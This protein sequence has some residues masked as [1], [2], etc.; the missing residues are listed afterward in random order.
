MR[1]NVPK[2]AMPDGNGRIITLTDVFPLDI[3]RRYTSAIKEQ[4]TMINEGDEYASASVDP[5]RH[6]SSR[7]SPSLPI[8]YEAHARTGDQDKTFPGASTY[9]QM[10]AGLGFPP[11]VVNLSQ[12]VQSSHSYGVLP[13]KHGPMDGLAIEGERAIADRLLHS[14]VLPMNNDAARNCGNEPSRKRG[15]GLVHRIDPTP[16]PNSS[17]NGS[18]LAAVGNI[19]QIPLDSVIRPKVTSPVSDEIYDNIVRNSSISS[20]LQTSKN[21]APSGRGLTDL[22]G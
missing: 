9:D 8:F 7:V 11:K 5:I 12:I 18:A 2:R 10:D 1:K 3:F 22:T 4:A 20:V 17:G 19:S 6:T 15:H 14:S 21:A 13:M 16:R